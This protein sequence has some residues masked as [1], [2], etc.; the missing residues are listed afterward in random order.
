MSTN[1]HGSKFIRTRI[2]LSA[3]I[4]HG[5]SSTTEIHDYSSGAYKRNYPAVNRK[6]QLTAASPGG[7]PAR[8][9]PSGVR[10]TQYTFYFSRSRTCI[11]RWKVVIRV[12]SALG[13][14]ARRLCPHNII[15]PLLVGVRPRPL[16]LLIS[17]YPPHSLCLDSKRGGGNKEDL[18]GHYCGLLR[19]LLRA[20]DGDG[21]HDNR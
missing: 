10:A 7:P 14:G 11:H 9:G 18:C 5:R 16:T 6:R 17:G 21:E 8:T 3:Q 13:L 2:R 4:F 15:Y 19:E 12:I 20:D 1:K